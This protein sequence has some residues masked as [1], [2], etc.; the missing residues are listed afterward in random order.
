MDIPGTLE[1]TCVP[2]HVH[3]YVCVLNI[4]ILGYTRIFTHVV[5]Y[6]YT[7]TP[8]DSPWSGTER[9]SWHVISCNNIDAIPGT[10]CTGIS[11]P[12]T[13]IANIAIIT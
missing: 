1:N 8:M 3:V 6:R 7:C 12:G 5:L 10:Y 9:E 4:A 11:I 2:V 13:C